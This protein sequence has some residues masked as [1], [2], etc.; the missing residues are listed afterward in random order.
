MLCDSLWAINHRINQREPHQ[1]YSQSPPLLESLQP[2]ISLPDIALEDIP[3]DSF[4]KDSS[5]DFH[6]KLRSFSKGIFR[7]ES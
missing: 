6:C 1:S 4:G 7:R 2:F 5:E 3:T